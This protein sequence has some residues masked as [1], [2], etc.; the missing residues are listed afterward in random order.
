VEESLAAVVGK[1]MGDLY[2]YAEQ[3]GSDLSDSDYVRS[4]LVDRYGGMLYH[5]HGIH[6]IVK[7]LSMFEQ[8]LAREQ[9][10]QQQKPP[11]T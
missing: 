9:Q 4:E 1:T 3:H 10:Q 7:R 8:Q 6:G 2:D 11:T 5:L